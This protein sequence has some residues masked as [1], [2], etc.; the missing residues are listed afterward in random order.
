MLVR[1]ISRV[2]RVVLLAYFQ[3]REARTLLFGTKMVV[4][5]LFRDFRA[6]M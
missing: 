6:Y 3:V 2:C 5:M 1:S 4:L